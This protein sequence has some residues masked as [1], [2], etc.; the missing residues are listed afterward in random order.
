MHFN[1]LLGRHVRIESWQ[2]AE[3]QPAIEAANMLGVA[4]E[5]VE[6]PWLWSDQFDCNIQT[7]GTIDA[8]HTLIARGDTHNGPFSLLALDA[9]RRLRAVV[10]INSGRDMG[11]CKRLV[12][13]GKVLDP[14][15]L[16]DPAV[17]LRSL[18]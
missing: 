5:Y 12:A 3:N 17:G 10:A 15:L 6:W 9:D 18:L 1:P 2:V 8:S 11:A 13:S 14:A 16:A 7:L 4:Q